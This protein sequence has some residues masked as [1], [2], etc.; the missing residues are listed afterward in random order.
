MPPR[1]VIEAGGF[2]KLPSPSSPIG[3]V[4]YGT[5]AEWNR[6]G[7][8]FVAGQCQ[9]ILEKLA[10]H[11]PETRLM[12]LRLVYNALMS[13]DEEINLIREKRNSRGKGKEE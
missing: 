13:Y 9:E 8:E 4:N 2:V 6:N 5:L 12:M 10:G 1:F 7:D 11:S 3:R